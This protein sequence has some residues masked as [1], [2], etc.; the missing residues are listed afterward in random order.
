MAMTNLLVGAAR[1]V[2]HQSFKLPLAPFTPVRL[3]SVGIAKSVTE[4]HYAAPP[5]AV[6]QAEHMAE[7]VNRFFHRATA[8]LFFVDTDAEP[9]QRNYCALSKRL[10]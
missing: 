3:F 2:R 10:S 7:L 8:K 6:C 4:K 1:E 9:I 5:G